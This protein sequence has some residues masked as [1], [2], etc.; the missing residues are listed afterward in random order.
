MMILLLL[1]GLYSLA[2]GVVSDDFSASNLNTSLWSVVNPL[3]DGSYEMTGMQVALSIP[4]GISHDAWTNENNSL[5][6]LQNVSN[7]DFAVKAKFEGY[8]SG[9]FQDHGIIIQESNNKF[10]RFDIYYNGSATYAFCA[11]VNNTDSTILKNTQVIVTNKMFIRLQ[12]NGNSWTFWYS[13]DG[14][15][16]TTIHTFSQTLNVNQVGPYIGNKNLSGGQPAPAHTILVDYFFDVNSPLTDDGGVEDTQD[17]VIS[18]I[19][20][21]PSYTTAT[22]SWSTDEYTTS[23]VKYGLKPTFDDTTKDLR[24]KKSH[25]IILSG[26]I[27][28]KDYYYRIY[29]ADAAKNQTSSTFPAAFRTK[30]DDVPPVLNVW[31]GLSQRVEHLGDAQDDFNIMGNV[32]D[33]RSGVSSLTYSLNGSPAVALSVGDR[34]DGFGDGRRLATT[35]DYNADISISNL[36]PGI[37]SVLL[38]AKD[39]SGNTTTRTVTVNLESGT[40]QFPVNIDWSNVSDPQNVGQ[41]VDGQWSLD[42]DGLRILRMGYDRLFLIGEQEWQDY[43]ITVPVTINE[44]GLANPEIF[45]PPAVGVLMRFTGHII[46]GHRDWPP[47]QPKWG[48]QPFGG[49]GWLVWEWTM[50]SQPQ[51]N[52][53][54]GDQDHMTSYGMYSATEGGTYWMKMRC[55]TLPNAPNGDGV[56][57]YSWK[58]WQGSNEPG[59]WNFQHEQQSQYA[60]RKGGVALVVHHMDVT[61]GDITI[62]SLMNNQP[63]IVST[64]DSSAVKNQLY[65][66]QVVVKEFDSGDQ[67]TFSLL[68]PKPSWLNINS[69]SGLI[70]GTPGINDVGN[71]TVTVKVD[72]N[73]GGTDTQTYPLTVIDSNTPPV[74]TSSPITEAREGSPYSYQ[75]EAD[76]PD[77]GDVITYSLTVKPS[78]LSINPSSGLINGTPGIEDVGD[79]TV[80]VRVDDNNGGYGTQTYSL[81]VSSKINHSPEITSQPDTTAIANQLYQYQVIAV[82][83]DPGDTLTYQLTSGPIWLNINP[84]T[85]LIQGNPSNHDIAQHEVL[86]V[87]SDNHGLEDSQFYILTVEPSFSIDQYSNQIPKDF[88]LMQNY[89]NP[90]NPITYI[91]FGLPRA[92]EVHLEVFN[93]LG[94]KLYVL[95]SGR[96]P[97]GYHRVV[98]NAGSLPSGVYIYRLQAG[99]FLQVKKMILLK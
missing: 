15:N 73:N 8:F 41:Y 77:L 55:E 40:Y 32:Y 4:S 46:G 17:P 99:V 57:R 29:S 44:I 39:V 70:S 71:S 68:P 13:Q 76:D 75:V 85:G 98:F 50:P 48:Y 33:D 52:F 81:T 43:E 63:K 14:N 11:F 92:E 88:A 64:P 87:V 16:W 5:R 45:V 34:P 79:T 37:N 30:I 94:E 20:I 66:Y 90:F 6:L 58:I 35:G 25:A 1:T 62:V 74:I 96:R 69:S 67:L 23:K 9:G 89:P 24:L 36:N 18:N 80:T 72:D 93:A 21:I 95:S 26:L 47:A 83:Q 51:I 7:T 56:T 60:L 86:V 59:G 31:H 54:R 78:W 12:R 61:F 91:Y 10:L 28:G 82:D 84:N 53:Y 3:N 22:I 38:T 97:A 65:S 19:S 42:G 49:L 2:M 27:P